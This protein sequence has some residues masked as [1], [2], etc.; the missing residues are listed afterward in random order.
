MSKADC[1]FVNWFQIGLEI[2]QTDKQHP[3]MGNASLGATH[4]PRLFPS[5]DR[6]SKNKYDVIQLDIYLIFENFKAFQFFGI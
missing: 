2:D 5:S 6:I 3:P 4:C 1:P